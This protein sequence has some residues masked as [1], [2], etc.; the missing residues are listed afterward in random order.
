MDVSNATD[1]IDKLSWVPV[2]VLDDTS[3][4][5]YFMK[6]LGKGAV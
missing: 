1:G 2:Q 6:T 3:L 4:T 5:N